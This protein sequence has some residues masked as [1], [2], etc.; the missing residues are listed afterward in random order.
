MDI[1]AAAIVAGESAQTGVTLWSLR[2]GHI[3]GASPG[4]QAVAALFGTAAG[5][6]I[7]A[8]AYAAIARAGGTATM[9]LAVPNAQQWRT[10]AEL[11]ASGASAL[12]PGAATAG[13]WAL[14]AGIALAVLASTRAGRLLPD[15]T[16]L[17]I[18]MLLP[19]NAAAAAFAGA[20]ALAIWSRLRPASHE[21]FGSVV[22]AG[23]VAGESVAGLAIII[24]TAP[25]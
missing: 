14:A 19:V 17:G 24:A 9:K 13:A 12:P 8:L 18:G 4:A 21:A 1:G 11:A 5:A 10:L 2:A 22:A 3:L 20:L 16:A 23:I 25:R 15:A 6:L 7:S